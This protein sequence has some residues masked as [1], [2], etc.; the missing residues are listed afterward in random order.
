MITKTD[1]AII[2]FVLIFSFAVYFFC[3][4]SDN[5]PK[6]A[7]IE[8]DGKVFAEYEMNNI[9]DEK[10]VDVYGKNKVKITRDY[11]EVI[12]ADCPDKRDMKQGKITKAGQIIVCLPNKMTVTIK[13]KKE[14]DDISR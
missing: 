2:C 6:T 13:D 8:V 9:A 5:K 12:Y 10:I 1:W 7:V 4:F 3:G 11:A 14:Y